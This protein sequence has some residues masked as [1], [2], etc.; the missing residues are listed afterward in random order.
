MVRPERRGERHFPALVNWAATRARL[1][2]RTRLRLD[3]WLEAVELQ[4]YYATCGFVRVGELVTPDDPRLPVQNRNLAVALM[5]QPLSP[6]L[7]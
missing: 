4:A 2:G 3:T 1:S 7:T 5:E 6:G